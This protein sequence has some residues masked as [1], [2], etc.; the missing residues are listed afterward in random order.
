MP[1]PNTATICYDFRQQLFIGPGPLP[2][3]AVL[4]MFRDNTITEAVTGMLDHS[5]LKTPSAGSRRIFGRGAKLL[6]ALALPLAPISTAHG[7][8]DDPVLERQLIMQALE[9]D[10]EAL[11]MIVAGLQPVEEMAPRA[12]SVAKLAKE[13]Y[14]SFKPNVPGGAAKPEIWTNWDDY[15]KRME[16]FIAKSEE[17]VALAESGNKN[18]VIE[19]M[20]DAMPCKAC[21]DVYREKK[22]RPAT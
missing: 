4:R 19:I 8:I 7:Q 5:S 22:Q 15:S 20:V 17:M 12:R 11:G 10:A 18:A 16:S 13:S 1:P 3:Y 9:E 14:E 6:V 21:H 2:P